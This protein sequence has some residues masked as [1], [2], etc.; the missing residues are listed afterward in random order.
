MSKKAK[1]VGRYIYSRGVTTPNISCRL[2]GKYYSCQHRIAIE[3]IKQPKNL[4][5][6][7]VKSIENN[8]YVK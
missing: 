5:F 2:I 4:K 6:H 7:I 3:F 8:K 1:K